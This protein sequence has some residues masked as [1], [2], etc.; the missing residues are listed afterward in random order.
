MRRERRDGG[1]RMKGRELGLHLPKQVHRRLRSWGIKT[2]QKQR[3][4]ETA[5]GV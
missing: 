4:K 2:V 5:K 3:I 1:E